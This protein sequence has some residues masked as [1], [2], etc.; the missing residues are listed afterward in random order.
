[1]IYIQMKS[2]LNWFKTG[3]NQVN[4]GQTDSNDQHPG[5]LYANWSKDGCN[6]AGQKCPTIR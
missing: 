4:A 5:A 1:M 2:K 3:Q 6:A